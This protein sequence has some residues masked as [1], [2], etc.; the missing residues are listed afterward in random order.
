M[1]TLF[2]ALDAFDGSTDHYVAVDDFVGA[3]EKTLG[4]DLLNTVDYEYLSKKY[5]AETAS[6][7]EEAGR[8]Q[9]PNFYEDYAALEEGGIEGEVDGLKDGQV[10][11]KKSKG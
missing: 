7:K 2:T 4:N 6:T 3:F 5:R 9:Y 8:V 1:R 10:K 11:A